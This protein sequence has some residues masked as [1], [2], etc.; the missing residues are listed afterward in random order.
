M[1]VCRY[2]I[3]LVVLLLF[4]CQSPES[5]RP[6][7]DLT[8]ASD[9]PE[10]VGEGILSTDLNERDLT[11][12][13]DGSELFFTLNNV[14]NSVR[15]IVGVTRAGDSWS[16]P[17]VA[18]FSGRYKDIEPFFAPDGQRL[19]F[20]STRPVQGAEEKA[21]YDLWFVERTDTGWGE[22]QHLPSPVNTERDEFYPAVSSNGNLYFTTTDDSGNEDIYVSTWD[23]AGYAQPAALDSAINTPTYEFNAY[24]S[25]DENVL[26]FS[27]YGREDGFGGGDLYVSHK[28]ENGNWQ[29]A[30]NLGSEIN[31]PSLDYCPFIDWDNGILYFSSNRRQASVNNDVA[32]TYEQ[33]AEDSRGAMNGLG[34]LYKVRIPEILRPS[35]M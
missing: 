27:S 5:T 18:S 29:P 8:T 10:L 17:V 15:A 26:V 33:I 16:S 6:D 3:L 1:S 35:S 20:A 21:D 32:R 19:Y 24:I 23:G 22:A 13:P 28:D 25:P 11:I 9:Q 14:N 7:L 2:E 12:S 34:D 4:G 30:S 31:G